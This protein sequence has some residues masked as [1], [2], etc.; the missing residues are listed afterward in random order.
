MLTN[1]KFLAAVLAVFAT[2]LTLAAAD[3]VVGTASSKIG[4]AHV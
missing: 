1:K 4:R 3:Y 2:A